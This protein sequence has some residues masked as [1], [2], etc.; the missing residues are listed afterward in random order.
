MHQKIEQ[1]LGFF[2]VYSLVYQI[3]V[4]RSYL[5]FKN[6]THYEVIPRF[7]LK[8]KK[9]LTAFYGM[10]KKRVQQRFNG[11]FTRSM[12]ETQMHQTIK[13]TNQHDGDC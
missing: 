9:K 5:T 11:S 10:L 2:N 4:Q 8:L 12:G 3:R 1:V 6:Y 7:Y 13:S